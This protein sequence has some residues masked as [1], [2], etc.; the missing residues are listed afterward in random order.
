MRVTGETRQRAT[1]TVHD[2]RER[3]ARHRSDVKAA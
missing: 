1:A 2:A 3:I